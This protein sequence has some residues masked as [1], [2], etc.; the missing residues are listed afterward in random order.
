MDKA[1]YTERFGAPFPRLNL[2][3]IY[4]K[5]IADGATGVV[6]AKAKA[7]HRTCITDRDAFK[8]AERE[9]Q[10]FIIGAFDEA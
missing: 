4:D 7:I 2:P 5:Y 3:A 9:A 10:S 1:D 6:R 8:A